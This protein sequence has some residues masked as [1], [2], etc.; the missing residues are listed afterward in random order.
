[1][2]LNPGI[3]LLLAVAFYLLWHG[4]RDHGYVLVAAAGHLATALGFLV[5]D[6]M[7]PLPFELQ[8][9]PSNALFLLAGILLMG[10]LLGH[11][12]LPVP[13]RS[14]S[15]MGGLGLAALSYFLLVQPNLNYRI[16]SISFALA[17]ISFLTV[18]DLR[19]TGRTNLV[20]RILLWACLLTGINFLVRPI[21]I[22]WMEGGY[23]D[24]VGFQQSLYWTTVQF[25]QSL[26]SIILA[27]CLM[28][29][30]AQDLISQLQTDARTDTLSGVLNRR[31]FEDVATALL[32]RHE[33]PLAL[34]LADLDHFKQIN[35]HH[36]HMAGDAVI[37][38]F[39]R[40]LLDM[41]PAGA[42]KGRI[43][44]EE[45][46]LLVPVPTPE[47][48]LAL[49]S[50][51]RERMATPLDASIPHTTVSIGVTM[52]GPGDRLDSL[53]RRAD[54]AL[55]RAKRAGRNRVSLH[56]TAPRQE[57]AC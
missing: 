57:A 44:G 42:V 29:A 26:V 20:D 43:G 40:I 47:A 24:Y 27:L 12:R 39:G 36:G 49:A 11:Y 28:V 8:R 37:S 10:S 14:F 16:L 45:F 2:L 54:K 34:L 13:W 31:G 33:A 51:L 30:I 46:A 25:S 53:L 38:G 52:A 6:V 23:I 17:A 55:Y 50:A 35:D 9:I 7:P 15:I 21:A 5:Q 41:A 1:M 3:S 18:V 32:A 19:R 22:I 56:R 4:R 48:A